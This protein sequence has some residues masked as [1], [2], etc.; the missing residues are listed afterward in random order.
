MTLESCKPLHESLGEV[1]YGLS[2][3][4][5]YSGSCLLPTG[6]HGGSVIPTPFTT[7]SGSPRG[8]LMT[9]NEPV[10]TCGLITPWN[11]PLA[12]ITRKV[13]PMIAAGCTGVLKP[14]EHTPLTAI[15]LR[16]LGL[17]AGVSE[18]VFEVLPFG[19]RGSAAAFGEA[20]C[21]DDDVK[22][23]SFTGSTGV[24]RDLQRQAAEGGIVK[25]VSLELGG[26]APFVVFGDADM[27][28]AVDAAVKSKF[29][30]AGQTCVCSDRFLVARGREE[31]FVERMKREVERLKVGDGMEEGTDMGPLI[32]EQAAENVERKV[33][34]CGSGEIVTGGKRIGGNFFE[35]TIMV[36]VGVEE[37]VWR[38]ENFGPIVAIRSFD[39]EEEALD[40]IKMSRTGL[41]SYFVTKDV[42][43]I[44]RFGRELPNGLVG[45]NEGI[46]SS[47]QAPFGGV[48]ESGIGREGSGEGIEEY[49]EK[50]YMMINH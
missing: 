37:E 31:E 27:D 33:R 29:R 44:F 6:L 26:N 8:T 50:K 12:M 5:Y 1:S 49:M 3:L 42:G 4:T 39:D 32:T 18:G 41:A 48:G 17:R 43:R 20:V 28:T 15:A 34:D 11:F 14:S 35:P 25:R 47:A 10:G 7:P 36:G 23:I 24:G 13:G 46:M 9:S 19:G 16:E 2:F 40:V 45:V 38:D 22:K 21:K 30:N